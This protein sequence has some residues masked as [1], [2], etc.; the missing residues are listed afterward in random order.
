MGRKKVNNSEYIQKFSNRLYKL[1]ESYIEQ[2]EN[3][4]KEK[5]E[6]IIKENKKGLE[7]WKAL[8]RPVSNYPKKPT[9]PKYTRESFCKEV[10]KNYGVELSYKNY[11]L[12]TKGE[13]FPD[14]TKLIYALSQTLGVSFEY[15][16][17][18]SDEENEVTAAIEKI[19]PLS[20][21]AINT[22]RSISGNKEVI[23]ILNTLLSDTGAC[24]SELMNLHEQQYH[25][26]KERALKG[27]S[28]NY[29]YDIMQR[30]FISAELFAN[31]IEDHL[32]PETIKA[33]EERLNNEFAEEQYRSEHYAEYEAAI[34]QDIQE[35]EEQFYGPPTTKVISV[36]K[37]DS[38][39]WPSPFYY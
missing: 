17:G 28:A 4:R 24:F 20:P 13:A 23:T 10:S 37:G 12:Y 18:L 25:I 7:N 31:Y 33:F 21:E 26:Y 36:K 38:Q 9:L 29:D 30:R 2:K 11:N 14:A 22:L 1:A 3:E 15:L 32:S 27:T 34:L 5:N 19:I 6:E 39:Q 8:S 35:F 16:Y